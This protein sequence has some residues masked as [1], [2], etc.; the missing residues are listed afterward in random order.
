[1]DKTTH[2]FSLLKIQKVGK[3]S[4]CNNGRYVYHMQRQHDFV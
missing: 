1:M 4:D 2:C 3:Y